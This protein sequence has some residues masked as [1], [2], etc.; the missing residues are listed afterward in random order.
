[1][2]SERGGKEGRLEGLI[3]DSMEEGRGRGGCMCISFKLIAVENKRAEEERW[4]VY[5]AGTK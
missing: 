2:M 1:M 4:G 5:C 3:W